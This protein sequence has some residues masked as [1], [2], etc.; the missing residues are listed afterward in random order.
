MYRDEG[1]VFKQKAEIKDFYSPGIQRRYIFRPYERYKTLITI[2]TTA[3]SAPSWQGVVCGS[4][5][6]VSNVKSIEL[7]VQRSPIQ[8][9]HGS[10]QRLIS[11]HGFEHLGDVAP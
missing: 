7:A 9:E 6:S 10:R 4:L 3:C 1:N 5:G 8:A 2:L 11:A